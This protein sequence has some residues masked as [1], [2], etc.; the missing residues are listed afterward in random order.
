MKGFMTVGVDLAKNVFQVHGVDAAGRT[1]LRKQLR[2]E[3]MASF[4][5]QLPRCRVAMEACGG[6]HHWGR[7]LMKQGH[8][9][10][11]IAAQ[12]VRPFRKTVQKN[13]ANDAQ[14]ITEAA[15]RPS[16]RYVSVKS[17][18]HQDLQS[19]HRVRRQLIDAR[20]MFV[21]QIRGLLMEYGI[22]MDEGFGKYK[23]QIAE[24]L[25]NADTELSS[26][27]RELLSSQDQVV[28]RLCEDLTIVEKKLEA[29]MK[30]N[31][32]CQRLMKVPGVGINGASM[33][34][35]SV[36]DPR[37]FKNGRHVA[38][39]LGLVPRQFSSGE[40]QRSGHITKSGDNPLRAMLVNGARSNIMA[41][42]KKQGSD[43]RS[44]WI[45]K[46]VKE[47]GWNKATIAVANKNA[48]IMLN[49]YKYKQDYKMA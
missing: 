6:S 13:D 45:L 24:A 22:V 8:E 32:D 2:R 30:N 28:R 42:V 48:R 31:E 9:P 1:V 37:V 18:H 47:K 44:Q 27:A 43:K 33:F 23:E 15:L 26:V 4:F 14:A 12:F 35:A 39:W 19:L 49:I 5:A 38:A 16:M 21:N 17:V 10:L 41:T 3:E 34:M 20:I 46:L 40:T 29:L 25:E 11:L 36:G 7:K